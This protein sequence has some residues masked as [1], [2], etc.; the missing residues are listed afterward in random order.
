GERVLAD[1][2]AAD[3]FRADEREA[4]TAVEPSD[5]L[6]AELVRDPE[7]LVEAR[8]LLRPGRDR[9]QP[10]L[11]QARADAFRVG[12]VDDRADAR[13]RRAIESPRGDRAEPAHEPRE[14][15]SERRPSDP[16]TPAGRAVPRFLLLEDDDV[17]RG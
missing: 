7:L 15:P 3:R 9:E 12:E 4:G 14:A 5:V 6:E 1:D 17:E 13:G 11:R 16:E 8:I 2:T 10:R